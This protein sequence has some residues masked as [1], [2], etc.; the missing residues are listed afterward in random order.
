MKD[1][2]SN[3]AGVFFLYGKTSCIKWDADADAVNFPVKLYRSVQ[4]VF[5]EYWENRTSQNKI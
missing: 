2:F 4:S 1:P 3:D 5:L